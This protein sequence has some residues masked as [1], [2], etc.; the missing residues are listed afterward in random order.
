M[1]G[2]VGKGDMPMKLKNPQEQGQER[3]LDE[4]TAD[5][6]ELTRSVRNLTECLAKLPLRRYLQLIEKP[7]KLLLSNILA[8][9]SYGFG[10]TLGASLLIAL[11]INILSEL[12]TI[13][14][15]GHYLALIVKQVQQNLRRP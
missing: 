11:L 10:F 13:P 2:I 12:A 6:K 14:V 15:I 8:G 3:V 7:R 9:L 1:K 5:V 4:L